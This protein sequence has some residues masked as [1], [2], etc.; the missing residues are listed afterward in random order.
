MKRHGNKNL[1]IIALTTMS[2]FTLFTC[3]S[4]AIAWYQSMTSLINDADEIKV[5]SEAG[6]LNKITFHHYTGTSGDNYVFSS[7]AAG[8]I[9]YNWTTQTPSYDGDT[10]VALGRYTLL[11]KIHPLLLIIELN[12]P[13]GGVTGPINLITKTQEQFMGE[14]SSSELSNTGNPLSSV[15]KFSTQ[16]G[17]NT[18]SS[19]NYTYPKASLASNF[20]SFAAFD[21]NG[22]PSFGTTTDG[23]YVKSLF[24]REG[25]GTGITKIS[26]VIDYYSDLIE[27]V[28]G[29]FIGNETLNGDL[30]YYC[31]WSLEL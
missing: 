10:S 2:I 14:Y 26:I 19:N 28:Y 30:Q 6:L 1:K 17:V 24:T 23:Y 18:D 7:T 13:V 25:E 29:H 12:A 21:S 11:D 27:W 20:T 16:T 22:I 9:T 8:T 5:E 15:I 3:F 31:D 4:A